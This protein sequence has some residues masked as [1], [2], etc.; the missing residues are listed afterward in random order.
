MRIANI[1]DAS[2]CLFIDDSEIN[3]IAAKKLGWGR[4]AH[5]YE[6]GLDV[7]EGGRKKTLGVNGDSAADVEGIAVINDLEELRTIWP[8]VFSS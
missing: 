3:V 1:S 7:M 5:F 6:T 4:C 8:D 2:K